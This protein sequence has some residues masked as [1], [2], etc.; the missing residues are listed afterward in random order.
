M[1]AEHTFI[2]SNVF[3]SF[4]FHTARP[5]KTFQSTRTLNIIL[6]DN[7]CRHFILDATALIPTNNF[8]SPRQV[9]IRRHATFPSLL[10]N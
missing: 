5:L 6:T 7:F 4:L 9:I 10:L 8:F 2:V 1:A 3:V